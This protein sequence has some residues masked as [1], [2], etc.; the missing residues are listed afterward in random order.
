M[1]ESRFI[2]EFG[3]HKIVSIE[4]EEE[5]HAIIMCRKTVRV[6]DLVNQFSRENPMGDKYEMLDWLE[7]KISFIHVGTDE[8][9]IF[10]EPLVVD[11][12]ADE[13]ENENG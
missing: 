1:K 2:K 11:E 5:I 7:E 10:V 3:K 13:N 12:D 8:R 9:A 4:S 6:Q